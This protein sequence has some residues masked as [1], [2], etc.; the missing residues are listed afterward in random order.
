LALLYLFFISSLSLLYLFFISSLSLLYLFFISSS[1]LL[2]LVVIPFTMGDSGL[3][4]LIT[5]HKLDSS[6]V[7]NQLYLIQKLMSNVVNRWQQFRAPFSCQE[8]PVE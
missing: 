2:H 7:E 4:L 5:N 8:L 1:C 6:I 3:S